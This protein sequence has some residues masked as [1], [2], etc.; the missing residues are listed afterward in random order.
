MTHA[1]DK[2]APLTALEVGLGVNTLPAARGTT[3]DAAHTLANGALGHGG[4]ELTPGV[5]LAGAC[6]E[7]PTDSV[8]LLQGPRA[9]ALDG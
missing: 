6:L 3:Q 4:G 9:L 7:D 1:A 8:A 5:R 2:G